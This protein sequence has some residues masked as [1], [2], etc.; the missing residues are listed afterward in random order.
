MKRPGMVTRVQ[1]VVVTAVLAVSAVVGLSGSTA[2]AWSTDDGAV[3]F[4]NDGPGECFEHFSKSMVVDA[5]GN[6]YT[7]GHFFGVCD[8]DPGPGIALLT[9]TLASECVSNC[10]EGNYR[11]DGFMVKL[12]A[13]GSLVWAKRFGNNG[14]DSITDIALTP[15]GNIV[16]AGRYVYSIDFDADGV[17]DLVSHFS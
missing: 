13:A 9:S 11:R 16:V 17:M 3:A 4:F 5:T 10:V 8:F 7:G 12:D 2:G 6:M 15:A 1:K 14:T